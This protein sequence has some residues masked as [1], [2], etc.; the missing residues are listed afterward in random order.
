MTR[1]RL[2]SMLR[3]DESTGPLVNGRLMLYDD[4]CGKALGKCTCAQPGAIT[5][6]YGHN[7]SAKG[8]TFKQADYLLEADI[9]DAVKDCVTY[10]PWFDTLDEVR[11][12]VFVMMMFN[13]GPSRLNGFRKFLIA[14]KRG[15]HETAAVEMLAS[16]WAD[17]LGARA[18][19]L[20]EMWRS[21][22]WPL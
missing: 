19:R 9:D 15:E 8:L 12:A 14:A 6:G 21:G 11:Q 4:K 18:I 16:K 13:L 10:Y 7:F 3:T 20:A 1:E 17:D 5:G 2:R 22:A